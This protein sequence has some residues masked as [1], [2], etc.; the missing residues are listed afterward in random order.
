M[1]ALLKSETAMDILATISLAQFVVIMCLIIGI[2][3]VVFKFRD[4]I[5]EFLED[6]R[7]KANQKEDFINK[8]NGY[9]AKIKDLRNYHDTDMKDFNDRQLQYRQQSLEKQRIID[10]H[11]KEIDTKLGN[12][13]EMLNEQYEETKQIKRNEL[14]E[15]LLNMYRFYTSLENNPKQ[16][17]TEME[18]E[19]FWDLFEDYEFLG[20]N[21]FMHETVKP[22]MLALKV[23]TI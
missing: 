12:I 21:G 8:L 7:T 3:V 9:D 11:F 2:V 19:V 14:R 1:D 16:E 13:M 10:D 20:G 17:W 5:K 4:S 15:K 22:A 23:V 6:Y 18:A